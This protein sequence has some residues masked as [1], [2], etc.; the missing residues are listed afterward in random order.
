M[1]ENNKLTIEEALAA[2]AGAVKKWIEENPDLQKPDDKNTCDALRHVF[3][4]GVITWDDPQAMAPGAIGG[5]KVRVAPG[6]VILDGIV[7]TFS[8][9]TRTYVSYPETE[10]IAVILCRLDKTTGEISMVYRD[11]VLHGD[12]ILSEADAAELPI[13]DDRYYDTLICMVAIPANATEITADMVQDLREFSEFR[14]GSSDNL[15]GVPGNSIY[16]FM[17]DVR[18]DLNSGSATGK[19]SESKLRKTTDRPILVGDLILDFSNNL[20]SVSSVYDDGTFNL[21]Y[22]HNIGT[23]GTG[24]GTGGVRIEDDG[25]GNVTITTASGGAVNIT[26]DGNGNVTIGG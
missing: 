11:V 14:H 9:H 7:K 5:M 26:D 12:Q 18:E 13:R 24:D 19:W 1:S 20:C 4:S 2:T 17:G 15:S 22:I 23:G 25:N 10:R 21:S 3:T 16:V 8:G 6:E